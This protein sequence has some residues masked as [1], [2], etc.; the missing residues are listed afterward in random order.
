MDTL[1]DILNNAYI[2]FSMILGLYAVWLAAQGVK[3]SGNFW[4]AMWTNTGLATVIFGLA[5][6]MTIVGY[7]PYGILP[8]EDRQ[9][10]WVYYLYGIYFIISLPGLFAILK[11]N[12]NQRAGIFFGF[13]ALF[14]AAAAYRSTYFLIE[15]WDK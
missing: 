12:D 13:V 1:F 15:S 7:R 10:R 4:G 6:I 9:I 11:G 14:N 2:M 3:L 8:G 5:I